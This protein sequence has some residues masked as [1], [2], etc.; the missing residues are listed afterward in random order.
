MVTPG[1]VG[2]LSAL[3]FKMAAYCVF[4]VQALD[5]VVGAGRGGSLEGMNLM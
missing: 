4:L 3:L 2:R 5:T 1:C